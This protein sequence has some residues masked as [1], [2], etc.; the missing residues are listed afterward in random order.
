MS[1][2]PH[3]TP[4]TGHVTLL[5]ITQTTY[6]SEKIA[7]AYDQDLGTLEFAEFNDGEIQPIIKQRG[8]Y[9]FII[10]S[11]FQ[12]HKN[13]MEMLLTIDAARLM[14]VTDHRR[15]PPG[16]GGLH[17]LRDALLRLRPPGS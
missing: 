17:L 2:K 5:S 13:L 16:I 12:P 10:G 14:E 3:L 9:V 4:L 7:T 6:L 15:R 8:E 11:T 1:H